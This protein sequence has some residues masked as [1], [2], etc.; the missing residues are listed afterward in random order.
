[1]QGINHF[2]LEVIEPFKETIQFG[3]SEFF[4]NTKMSRD[5]SSN[6]LGTIVNI[7]A[8][9]EETVLK[10]G[11]QVIFD[12]TI[13]YRQLYKEGTQ[14]SVHLVDAEKSWYKIEPEMIVL[15]R[16]N[17]NQEWQGYKDNLMVSFVTEKTKEVSFGL[18]LTPLKE[19]LSKGKAIVKYRNAFLK[20]EGVKNGQEVFINPSCGVPF[21][22]KEET[23]YWIRS[24]DVLAV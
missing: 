9:G 19:T 11:F 24:K 10:K 2:I 1:M 18:V 14:E 5:R 21:F 4:V 7:P 23:L 3:E 12:A 13:L 22:F 20:E 6:R 17:E 8:A 15:F 16:E